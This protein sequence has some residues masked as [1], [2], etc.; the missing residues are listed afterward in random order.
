M[1]I[2][3]FI[4]MCCLVGL[5]LAGSVATAKPDAAYVVEEQGRGTWRVMFDR[6]MDS[7]AEQWEYAR[8]TQNR[9]YLRKADR[10]ML[11]L[12]R[13]WPNSKEAPWAARARADML[14]ARG[15]LEDA[16]D[17]YQYL[18]DNYSSR[19][20]EYD[21][22]L[23]SQF[24]I[25][26]K[27]MNKRRMRLILGGFRSPAYAVEY[28]EKVIRNGPQWSRAA[29]AQLLIGQ[30]H[31]EEDD[32]EL[33]I[34][35]YG[36]LGYRYPE[37]RFAEEAAWQQIVCLGAL[38][39]EYPNSPEMLDRTLTATTV[40]LSTFPSS[41]RKS[42]II[43]LRNELY[44]VK[45]AAMFAKAAFYVNVPK[46][47]QAAILYDKALIEEYPKSKLVPQAEERIATLE[48]MLSRPEEKAPVAPH[49]K[50]L[51]FG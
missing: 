46:K 42:E 9:G 37:S 7:S 11:Y 5:G 8:A 26:V 33:A 51:P 43:A 32:Y 31:Q 27:V 19:M 10:R 15:K 3:K 20:A 2:H 12:V 41:G 28:F 38:H 21:S 4:L 39:Q 36:L 24:E 40:F 49:S 1:R 13:R 29:E 6:K 47:P 50:P 23:D 30:C 45:A 35:A 17:A 48:E 25:A 22:V 34:S 18:I 44:E 14:L 16:F